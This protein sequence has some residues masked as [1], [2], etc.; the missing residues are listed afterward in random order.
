MAKRKTSK[1]AGFSIVRQG[2]SAPIIVTPS[3]A[4]ARHTRGR[5][6][7]TAAKTAAGRNKG[8]LVQAGVAYLLGMAESKGFLPSTAP[9]TKAVVGAG[10]AIAGDTMRSPMLAD[11]GTAVAVIGAYEMGKGQPK[12]TTIS[13]DIDGEIDGDIDGDIFE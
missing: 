9:M 2:N 5:A 12:K 1:K 7:G 8:R 11:A 4:P 13:G 10:V 6:L 3:T